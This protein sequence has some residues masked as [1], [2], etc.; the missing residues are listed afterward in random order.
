VS[1]LIVFAVYAIVGIAI[2]PVVFRILG[3]KVDWID[4]VVASVV[5]A[6]VA[7]I[8]TAGGIIS[9]FLMAG[10]LYWRSKPA[11]LHVLAA[12]MASRFAMVGV[13]FLI[14]VASRPR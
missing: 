8:P 2:P 3:S 14:E 1:P 12:V 4:I 10:I 9:L 11:A 5:A 6:L 13:F 7:L